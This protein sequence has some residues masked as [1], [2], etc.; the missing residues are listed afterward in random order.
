VTYYDVMAAKNIF[1]PDVGALKG[2]M[3]RQTSEAVTIN[4]VPVPTEIME[5][6]KSVVVATDIMY[7]NKILILVTI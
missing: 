7:L 4:E 5:Q 6:C 2:K 1:G 3:V